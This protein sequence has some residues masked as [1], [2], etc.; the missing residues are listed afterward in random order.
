MRK[1]YT[2]ISLCIQMKNL[3][4]RKYTPHIVH[5]PTHHYEDETL[6]L[7]NTKH[8]VVVHKLNSLEFGDGTG[9]GHVDSIQE[10][11]NILAL[12]QTRLVDQ[13][14]APRGQIDVGSHQVQLILSALV[15]RDLGISEHV[16][17]SD[18]FFSQEVT[19]LDALSSVGDGSGD[20]EMRVHQTQGVLK[21]LGH[22]SHHV[23]N[24]RADRSQ[25]GDLL[26]QSEV[27]GDLDFAAPIRQVDGDRKMAEV[28]LQLSMG[29]GDLDLAGRDLHGNSLGDGHGLFGFDGF[30]F[31]SVVS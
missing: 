6:Q 1:P 3:K 23:T 13:S 30:H 5:I 25:A 26:R 24:V 27:E 28:S 8:Q 11:T 31:G 12:D 16:D 19:D 4:C 2:P 22:T 10:F 14:S 17:G 29:T 21:L 20:R 15:F 9:V 18:N 7:K